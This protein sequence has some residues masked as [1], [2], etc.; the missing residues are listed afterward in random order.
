[1]TEIVFRCENCGY[2]RKLD[3]LPAKHSVLGAALKL[4]REEDCCE[5]PSYADS[6]GHVTSLG[7]IYNG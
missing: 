6:S 3:V 5:D 7:F 1:M 2:T 4:S